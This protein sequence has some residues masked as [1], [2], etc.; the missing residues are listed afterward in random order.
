[1][2]SD[3][4]GRLTWS[5]IDG[6]IKKYLGHI[7]L[8][9]RK[10]NGDYTWCTSFWHGRADGGYPSEITPS[11]LMNQSI[12]V[13]YPS[14][15]NDNRLGLNT[16]IIENG[17]Y[18][19][20]SLTEGI[21]SITAIGG[22]LCP[23]TTFYIYGIRKWYFLKTELIPTLKIHKLTQQQ[24]DREKEAGNLD[25]SALYLTPDDEIDLDDYV[26]QEDLDAK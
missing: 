8:D 1:M 6:N 12:G 19:S 25:E 21:H 16:S 23:G 2:P 20:I 10:T 3:L 22:G 11:A 13:R 9:L 7:E 14:S 4:E 18:L 17:R 24:Y 26:L 15:S 5:R